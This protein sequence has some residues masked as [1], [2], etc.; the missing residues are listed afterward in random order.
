MR[1]WHEHLSLWR[2][3]FIVPEQ[4]VVD[5]KLNDNVVAAAFL[6]LMLRSSGQF[7]ILLGT[8]RRLDNGTQAVRVRNLIPKLPET[9]K[10]R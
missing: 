1:N 7:S 4:C 3:S 2:T 6:F 5:T 10:T 9:Q 8:I